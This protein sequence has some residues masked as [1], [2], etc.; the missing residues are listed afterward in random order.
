MNEFLNSG[1]SSTINEKG[2]GDK[3]V[4]HVSP[5]KEPQLGVTAKLPSLEDASPRET[6]R[7]SSPS[8]KESKQLTP[9][10]HSST[11]KRQQRI[12]RRIARGKPFQRFSE[13][14]PPKPLEQ[15]LGQS[16]KMEL[17][18][19][20]LTLKGAKHT[21]SIELV[22]VESPA[23]MATL[24][25]SHRIYKIYQDK[26]HDDQ[27]CSQKQWTRFLRNNP[28]EED[29]EESDMGLFHCHYRLDGK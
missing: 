8:D 15:R 26:I 17:T 19:D 27:D 28:F 11:K 24:N 18:D 4:V 25:E 21:L 2:A 29:D 23:E 3:G 9:K 1:G 10:R 22:K 14:T 6:A 7:F 5:T 20:G 16:V 12:E 13:L